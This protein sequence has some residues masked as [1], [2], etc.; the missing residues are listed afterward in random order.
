MFA[1]TVAAVVP[2]AFTPASRRIAGPVAVTVPITVPI[3]RAVAVPVPALSLR[4]ARV[5]LRTFH[6]APASVIAIRVRSPVPI[7]ITVPVSIA[8][9][10]SE[11]AVSQ[12]A[13]SK[14]AVPVARSVSACSRRTV[15]VRVVGHVAVDLSPLAPVPF[16][17]VL[18]VEPSAAPVI[19]S[20]C[21]K[22][23]CRISVT[24]A[25]AF[26]SVARSSVQASANAVV[27][28]EPAEIGEGVPS[29]RRSSVGTSGRC[30]RV[31]ARLSRPTNLF[32]GLWLLVRVRVGAALV[33]FVRRRRCFV[34]SAT[35]GFSCGLAS[36]TK[37]DTS[38]EPL[39]E[40]LHPLRTPTQRAVVQ[41]EQYSPR[42]H[43]SSS[44][45]V[46][47]LARRRRHVAGP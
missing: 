11:V 47:L 18:A 2:V 45:V 26:T 12:V 16:A 41:L 35:V 21:S 40:R 19:L 31:F 8:V 9:T 44:A 32:V 4:I 24:N 42:V 5:T 29:G 27:A 22:M 25:P 34:L 46:R 6:P 1:R 13:V 17:F 15:A 30:G 14:V 36:I 7:A 37:D 10:V 23:G 38:P 28:A 20:A 3:A 39:L 43:E 33:L